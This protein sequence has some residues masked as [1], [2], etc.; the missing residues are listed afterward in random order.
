M[1]YRSAL[2]S[3]LLLLPV[4]AAA[5]GP[6]DAVAA[7]EAGVESVERLQE[8]DPQEI[9]AYREVLHRFSERTAEFEAYVKRMVEERKAEE[10]ARIARAY[11]PRLKALEEA[12]RDRREAAIL[13][14]R[15]FVERYPDSADSDNVRFRLAEL[16]YEKAV[17][18]WLVASMNFNEVAAEYDEKYDRAVEA[19]EAGDPTLFEELEELEDPR[20]DLGPAIELYQQI[21]ARNK[22]LPPEERWE[23]LDR[24]YYSLGFSY[25]STE[26]TQHDFTRARLAFEE[27][28]EVVGETSSLADAAHMFLGKILF[29]EEQRYEDALDQY[30]AVVEKGSE[31]RYYPDASFQLAWIY[32][33]LAV[34]VPEYEEK[35]L[36]LFT[37]I[38]D[39]SHKTKEDTG[40][41]SDYAGDA[42]LNLAR[43][44]AE[45]SDRDFDV[46]ALQ[47][48]QSY[49]DRVGER[50]WEREVYVALAEVLAGC[51]PAP[52]PQ[53]C[54]PGTVTGGRYMMDE[55]IEIYERL[56]TDPRWVLKPENPSYQIKKIWLLPRRDEP[57]IEV[58]LPREQQVF[59]QRFSETIRDEET[60]EEKPNPWWVANRNNAEALD[61]VRRYSESSLSNVATGLL[62]Q[63]IA[64]ND[65]YLYRKAAETYRDYLDKFPIADNFFE[66]QWYLAN[67][68]LMSEPRDPSR[69]WEPAQDAVREFTSLIQSRDY[70]PY[71]DGSVYN[72]I[73]A[74]RGILESR[75]EEYGP[76]TERPR[77]AQVEETITTE[78]GNEV[79]LLVISEDHL[80]Y[81]EAIDLFLEYPLDEPLEPS[82]P[83]FREQ[84]AD[85]LPYLLYT[86]AIIYFTHGRFKEM[87]ERAERVIAEVP[88]TKEASFS[89]RLIVDS[90]LLEGDL[91]EVR[92]QTRRF[93]MMSFDD[94]DMKEKF[95]S[96]YQNATARACGQL[97]D[98]KEYLEAAR[99]FEDYLAEFPNKDDSNYKG[100]LY[101]AANNYQLA[102][103]AEQANELFERYVKLYPRDDQSRRLMMRIAG[104]YES[105]LDLER[106]V[107]YYS[108]LIRND[109]R[110][111]FPDHHNA[112]Y[113]RAFLKV[114][115]GDH[116]G[117]A[118]G[119]EEYARLFP[120]KE[121]AVDV[122]YGAGEQWA[123][124]SDAEARNFYTRFLRAHGPGRPRSNPNYVIEAQYRLAQLQPPGSRAYERAMDEMLQTFDQYL[125]DGV[126]F[127]PVAHQ[128]AGE[129]AIHRLGQ[130]YER[131]TATQL[132]RDQDR[133]AEI[134][135]RVN[136]EDLPAFHAKAN[137]IVRTYRNFSHMTGGLYFIA[138]STLWLAELGLG[139][140]CPRG[141]DD[142]L[143][144]LW[145]EIYDTDIRPDF[146]VQEESAKRGFK[147]LIER[148][149]ELKQHSEW[150]D[151]AYSVLN[152]L[153]PMSFPDV[154]LE[155]RGD[156]EL[157]SLPDLGPVGIELSGKE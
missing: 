22:D 155:L 111:E 84:R 100:A 97:S 66:V 104:N 138:R 67:A 1:V 91:T 61:V 109:P 35:A 99:C 48:I 20:Q 114:G 18:E 82:L 63:A 145:Y 33:K 10:L 127:R 59:S 135:R 131:L 9:Q 110:R 115:L 143:C 130:E 44:F 25:L 81:I 122:M 24:A 77:N 87:R 62:Q 60:G 17:D 30:R 78:F 28:L 86:P 133:D 34:L 27:M 68:L 98:A 73:A 118:Q 75:V 107:E 96:L 14:M 101:N 121:D 106:A 136:E 15:S 147:I 6:G 3:V 40:R 139:M 102:G 117:A 152:S 88:T 112:I 64:E 132:T 31:S 90:Y 23:H 55:A 89:A 51:I 2:I 71:G 93:S 146:E 74:K 69:P 39:E 125:A 36:E 141:F 119:Y 29:E 49:F 70:H 45:A 116:R 113:N 134:I 123:L 124:V 129:W 126:E 149:R 151:K 128:Y 142:D 41:A 156:A 57:N 76:I 4:S 120:D 153:D 79:E 56:Q 11:D 105:T 50:P 72:I 38:L 43:M 37:K 150:V 140:E 46:T 144:D 80:S 16:Y 13:K 21:I 154:K 94:P 12:E 8:R 157:Q 52:N 137:Q 58:E 108:V 53:S 83:D 85:Q 42:R 103:R 47:M 5:Q 92:N 95:A 7:A 19:L 148:A 54:R 26:A 32:Y 65:P